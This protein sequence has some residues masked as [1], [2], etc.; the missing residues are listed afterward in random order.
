[1]VPVTAAQLPHGA[2]FA[3]EPKWDGYRAAVL[4]LGQVQITSRR[5]TDLTEVFPDLVAAVVDQVPD[6]TLLDTELVVMRDGRLSF[7][8]LQHR[9]AGR[10]RQ[11]ARL[12]SASPASLVIFDLMLDRGE[13]VRALS[14]TDRRHRLDSQAADWRPPL[15]ITP[16]TTDRATA[17]EWMESLAPMGIEGIF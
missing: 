5:G 14:W 4:H 10:T 3:H 11:A 6:N 9:M 7:D 12:A 8:A 15:Q 17:A 1:M 13:D 16:Y 2:A